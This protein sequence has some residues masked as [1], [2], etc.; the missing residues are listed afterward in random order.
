MSFQI[1]STKEHLENTGGLALAA[2]VARASGLT[3]LVME[4]RTWKGA[5]LS[6]FGL[7]VM[8]RSSYEEIAGFRKDELFKAAFHLEY[9]PAR[10]T[11]RIYLGRMSRKVKGLIAM[12]FNCNISLL[13]RVAITPIDIGRRRYIPVDVDVSTLDNGKS[14]KEGVGR[15]YMGTDGYAPIFSYIGTEGYMLDC[16]LRPGTQHS[17]KGTP[18][19]LE[20][21]L[22]MIK[23]LGLFHPVLFRLDSGNDAIDTIKKLVAPDCFFLIKRNLRRESLE[24]WREIA[25]ALGTARQ[26]RSGKTVY[27]GTITK[28]HP[29]A[30]E[31]MPQFDIVFE[32]T[33]RTSDHQG[34]D[35]LVPEVEVDTW[36]TNLYE[37]PETIIALYHDH[38]TSEQFH[39]EL[40]TDMDVER[41]PSGSMK[42][43][44]LV[45]TISMLA[46]NTL[47]FIGQSALSLPHLLP[48]TP[49][50]TQ[51]K[52][53]RKVIADL[54]LVGC[55]LVQHGRQMILRIWDGNPW[56]PVFNEL[57]AEFLRL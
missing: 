52:R 36:W 2:E 47:R 39:S 28:S 56:L 54:I 17:Q 40:K 57:Y 32:V 33:V 6:M 26:A 29:K 18:E 5:L 3:S 38:G 48:I 49:V 53:L 34:N 44:E 55:K 14:H 21:N 25:Q 8:G 11:L 15:T 23:E 42:V 45:L 22:A 9:V 51:R 1:E 4:V 35:F 20:R 16:Q 10:E 13:K 30:D 43:N 41:L 46:F 24:Q 50:T 7:L 12:L 19:F 37:S 31:D 27:T